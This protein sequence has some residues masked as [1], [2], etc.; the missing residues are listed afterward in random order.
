MSLTVKSVLC[1]H[2]NIV[3]N[4]KLL[5]TNDNV[6]PYVVCYELPSLEIRK[7]LLA[8]LG[9]VADSW[10]DLIL[11]GLYERD[12]TLYVI[13]NC[14]IPEEIS[15]PKELELSWKAIGDVMCNELTMNLL[16]QSLKFL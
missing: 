9:E 6:L 2:S 7:T 14:V 3:N 11:C 1:L 13:Y 4:H 8:V 12:H 15:L 5:V 16:S 10:N